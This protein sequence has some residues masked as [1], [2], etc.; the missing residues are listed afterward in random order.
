MKGSFIRWGNLLC[1]E[2]E[3]VNRVSQYHLA[4]VEFLDRVGLLQC[5]DAER[6]EYGGV[7]YQRVAL[8]PVVDTRLGE[9]QCVACMGVVNAVDLI[10][11]EVVSLHDRSLE[12][13]EHAPWRHIARPLGCQGVDRDEV[14]V[15]SQFATVV[16][17][18]RTRG[19]GE[20]ADEYA[21]DDRRKFA[22]CR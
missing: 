6:M 22:H 10:I 11:G 14:P 12:G 21:E 5:V 9:F 8:R 16:A 1:T 15:L 19:K 18:E 3:T 7:F 20:Q 2:V 13:P 4:A 17:I